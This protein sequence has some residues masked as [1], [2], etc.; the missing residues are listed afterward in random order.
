V[1]DAESDTEGDAEHPRK[2]R[3]LWVAKGLGP[4]GMEQLLLT[5]AR[6]GDRERIEYFAAYVVERPNS[7]VDQLEAAGVRCHA[8][9]GPDP[10]DPRWVARLVA[11]VR[12]EDID[13]VHVHSPYVAA[14]VRPALRSLPRR[15]AVVYTEHNSADCYGRATRWSNLATYP[16]DDVRY[17]VSTAAKA[18]TPPRLQR[19]T[20][21]LVHGVDVAA[22]AERRHARA[23]ARVELEVASGELVVGIVANLRAAKAYPVLLAA[24]T[25]V[26]AAEPR[27][28]FVSMG[29]GP[30]AEEMAL[31]RDELGLGDRFGFMGFTPD[32]TRLMAGLDVL[33]LSSDV[34]GTPV[35]VMEAKA[36]GLPVVATRVGGL[37]EMIDDGVDGL[38]VPR[39][40]PD[41]LAAALLRVLRDDQLRASMAEASATSAGRYDASVAIRREDQRYLELAGRRS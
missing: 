27:A 40:D 31:R 35:S 38:L 17:A 39:R 33:V 16:M 21:V 20:E 37:P 18:S 29:Q 11:L 36:L 3:V 34:E 14:L 12:R 32:P 1:A 9:G 2:V 23:Q 4:G 8:L 13:V 28:R 15:P 30:L 26:V 10:R 24:A 25:Q 5:H 6:L 22:L 7:I 19:R 41:A